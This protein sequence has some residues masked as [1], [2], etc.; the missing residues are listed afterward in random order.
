MRFIIFP[1]STH[2][3]AIINQSIVSR[4][5]NIF[6][7]CIMFFSFQLFTHKDPKLEVKILLTFIPYHIKKQGISLNHFTWEA[8]NLVTKTPISLEYS[9]LFFIRNSFEISW[10]LFGCWSEGK[11]GFEKI[12]IFL[13]FLGKKISLNLNCE[14]PIMTLS[15]YCK[16]LQNNLNFL[17]V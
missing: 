15:C 7:P 12:R 3:E 14:D 9:V 13:I 17:F 11:K 6:K 10:P 4:K 1:W 16:F 2:Q 5:F 8:Y